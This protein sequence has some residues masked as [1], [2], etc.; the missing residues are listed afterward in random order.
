M[1]ITFAVSGTT[2]TLAGLGREGASGLRVAFA[3]QER[4]VPGLR[5]ASAT[6]FNDG[7]R[8][9]TLS[10]T[11]AKEHA[12]EAAARDYLLQHAE[13]I[14]RARGTLTLNTAGATGGGATRNYHGTL[15]ITDSRTLGRTSFVTYQATATRA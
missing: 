11:M 8:I 12:S 13:E 14:P 7:G 4:A 15:R 1:Q 10:W 2:L 6:L 5:A 9:Y 3:D